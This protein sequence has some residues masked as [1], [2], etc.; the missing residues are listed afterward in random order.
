MKSKNIPNC[1]MKKK[2]FSKP[3]FFR[4]RKKK[5]R[6]IIT[7]SVLEQNYIMIQSIAVWCFT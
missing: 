3:D 1:K 2:I 5:L 4:K 7:K 6:K